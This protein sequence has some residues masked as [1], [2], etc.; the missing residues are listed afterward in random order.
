MTSSLPSFPAPAP[1]ADPES[2][3]YAIYFA[4]D[5]DT[6]LHR[7]GSAWLG[8]DTISGEDLTQPNLDGF[9]VAA[10]KDLTATACGYGFHA[11][12]KPPFHLKAGTSVEELLDEAVHFSSTREA[13]E[14]ALVP[15][16]LSGFIAF[17]QKESKAAMRELA[18]DC[19]RQFDPFR[20]LPGEAELEKR[21]AAG[22]SSQ[23]E[24]ML[25]RWGYPY[26][27]N[28]F[29][30]HMTLS[31]RIKDDAERAALMREVQKHGADA[32]AAPVS[33]DAISVFCQENRKAPFLR[34]EHFP[35][36]G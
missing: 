27:M 5:A 25:Q 29:R 7:F 2:P 24:L 14:V 11:T 6:E 28:E 12:L 19:V 3:R 17:M 22:L 33:I 18:A 4:P 26:V 21:R 1:S 36:G 10:Q 20:A 23:Q 8:R 9:D 32:I 34:L 30:F 15:R 16:D 31:K 35:F 13:F